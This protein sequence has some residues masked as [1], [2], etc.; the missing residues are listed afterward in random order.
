VY[1]QQIQRIFYVVIILCITFNFL[2]KCMVLNVS[3]SLRIEIEKE[4]P[5]PG[6]V[7]EEEEKE[8]Q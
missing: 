3:L 7:E 2:K 1:A 8:I 6:I 5:G 4:I